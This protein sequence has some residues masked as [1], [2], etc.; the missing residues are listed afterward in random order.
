MVDA[1][2]PYGKT[3]VCARIPTRNFLGFIEPKEKLQVEDSRA[4]ID[5]A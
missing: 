3:E 2:I 5:R 1:W 4:E